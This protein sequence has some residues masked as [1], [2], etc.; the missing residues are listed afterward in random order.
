[1]PIL[2]LL[3]LL[4]LTWNGWWK[5]NSVASANE[6]RDKKQ[7]QGIVQSWWPLNNPSRHLNPSQPVGSTCTYNV[8]VLATGL[9]DF[10]TLRI[11]CVAAGPLEKTAPN[12]LQRPSTGV[13][14]VACACLSLDSPNFCDLGPVAKVRLYKCSTNFIFRHRLRSFSSHLGLL[15][16]FKRVVFNLGLKCTGKEAHRV[17]QPLTIGT[18]VGKWW[19]S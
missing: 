8:S 1:M 4:K 16:L 17:R 11:R 19:V 2:L 13:L 7:L 12:A 14:L 3:L 5:Q 9:Y 10:F 18:H 6:R 15:V